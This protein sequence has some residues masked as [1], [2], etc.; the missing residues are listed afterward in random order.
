LL[1]K[2]KLFGN[3]HIAKRKLYHATKCEDAFIGVYSELFRY[4]KDKLRK[5]DIA[6]T[7]LEKFPEDRNEYF[8]DYILNDLFKK[9]QLKEARKFFEDEVKQIPKEDWSDG[10]PQLKT[11]AF[12]L[13]MKQK[14]Y[15]RA[16]EIIETGIFGPATDNLL[17]GQLY[18]YQ[19][20]YK[21][22]SNYF[23][24]VITSSIHD[25]DDTQA[26]YYYLLACHI[27]TNNT[28]EVREVLEYAKLCHQ[29]MVVF[30][31]I[32]FEY[33]D[34]AETT[35]K[36][37]V[38]YCAD[39]ELLA[40]RAQGILAYVQMSSLPVPEEGSP[41][42][43]LT[44]NELKKV[45]MAIKSALGA[46]QFYPTDKIING[47]LS[48]LYFYKKDFDKALKYKLAVSGNI[49]DET[50]Y[51]D[52]KVG[53]G[54]VSEHFLDNYVE[55][56]ENGFKKQT[57]SVNEYVEHKLSEDVVFF[58]ERKDFSTITKLYKVIKAN[59]Y[60]ISSLS[61]SEHYGEVSA[62][63][64]ELAYS[65]VEDG[66]PDE[67]KIVYELY[68]KNNPKSSSA[69]NNL[70]LIYERDGDMETA[71]KFVK[72]AKANTKND[73]IVE[74]NYARLV[75]KEKQNAKNKVVKKATQEIKVSIPRVEVYDDTG[76][77]LIDGDKVL[78][79]P[80]KNMPFR[81]LQALMPLGEVKGTNNVFDLSSTDRS[82]FN[83][84]K[85]LSLLEKQSILKTRIKEL[86]QP[87]RKKRVRVSLV[88]DD[89]NE[90][91]FLKRARRG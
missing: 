25:D 50:I 26:S 7:A 12:K 84:E 72:K 29:E 40:M 60:D 4:E 15:Q 16:E 85:Q 69:L 74:R 31:P 55:F 53:L 82:K 33:Y 24:K 86:Q 6:K 18:Y 23:K 61:E 80:D 39:D 59:I 11:T 54:D 65:L 20:E 3:E 90:T 67:A 47:T 45:D 10:Y 32:E 9:G 68:L 2:H 19:S 75:G 13:T 35:L 22:A 78:I 58:Y 27:R 83:E 48:N 14:D 1:S 87:L 63:L 43:A 36:K 8:I 57:L 79:G 62:G 28:S 88:F 21:K 17:K 71:Q 30:Y 77:L 91:V 56:L 66:E 42:R 73:P 5:L 34:F 51:L 70:A 64:F 38:E 46:L 52:I 37:A 81:L 44:K 89:S 41:H 49:D 76:F